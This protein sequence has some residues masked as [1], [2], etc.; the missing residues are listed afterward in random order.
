MLVVDLFRNLLCSCPTVLFTPLSLRSN[1]SLQLE[2]TQASALTSL[3]G[4]TETG[5]F[6]ST[7]C[8]D[9][10]ALETFLCSQTCRPSVSEQRKTLAVRV[11]EEV[12]GVVVVAELTEA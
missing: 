11:D 8:Q 3:P 10:C 5:N 2:F 6:A 9:T 7:L 12:V 4:R 1:V